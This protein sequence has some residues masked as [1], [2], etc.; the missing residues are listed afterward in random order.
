MGRRRATV[1]NG[2]RGTGLIGSTVGVLAF[3]LF[4]LLA[5]QT[6]VRLY[7]TSALSAATFD[8]AR[9]VA[10]GSQ[11]A[12]AEQHARSTLGS[13]GTRPRFQWSV[14]ADDV[15]L[16]VDAPAPL[17]LPASWTGLGSIHRTVHVRRE[18]FRP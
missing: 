15:S 14:D 1:R 13:F 3:L 9:R 5:T 12:D 16:T 7:A 2:E 10:T 17:F 11:P 6:L 8:A 4:L 18:T